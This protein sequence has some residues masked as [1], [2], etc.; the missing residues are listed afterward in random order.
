MRRRPADRPDLRPCRAPVP[1][2]QTIRRHVRER[3]RPAIH[4]QQIAAAR[5][6]RRRLGD[7]LV[8]R[9]R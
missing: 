7:A 6:D 8:F 3:E 1:D 2:V 4:L 9:V 5:A